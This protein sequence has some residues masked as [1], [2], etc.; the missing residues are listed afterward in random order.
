MQ[1]YILKFLLDRNLLI[2]KNDKLRADSHKII[3]I[4]VVAVEACKWRWHVPE[5]SVETYKTRHK[6]EDRVDVI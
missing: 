5:T 1:K 2:S 4:F 3:N 6:P